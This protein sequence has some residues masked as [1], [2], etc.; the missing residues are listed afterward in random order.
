MVERVI[1]Q[2]LDDLDG[3]VIDGD[4]GETLRFSLDGSAFEIDLSVAHAA[5]LREVLKRYVAAARPA[6]GKRGQPSPARDSGAVTA[7]QEEL[8]KM[9]EW[10]RANGYV[11]SDRG[12]VAA[13]IQNAYR[14]AQ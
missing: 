4:L 7:H 10:A 1:R 3:S 6:T 5:E 14:A 2:R 8:R 11:L 13:E 12:R 9:R